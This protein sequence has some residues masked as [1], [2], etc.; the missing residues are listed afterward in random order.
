MDEL[1]HSHFIYCIKRLENGD[2][3]F[4]NRHYKPLGFHTSDWINYDDPRLWVSLKGL[5][6]K[7]AAKI[8]YKNEEN[9]DN[10][11]LYNDGCVP[12]RSAENMKNY[13]SRLDALMKL[14]HK[15][16]RHASPSSQE[17]LKP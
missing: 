10:I 5:T 17:G 11:Y 9:L 7:K 1:R 2:Y 12:T 14:T 3:I 8:S 15:K 4:L 6:A 16:P 13:L